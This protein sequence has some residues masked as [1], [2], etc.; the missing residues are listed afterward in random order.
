M[1]QKSWLSKDSFMSCHNFPFTSDI[2]QAMLLFLWRITPSALSQ[3]AEAINIL[4]QLL[5][6]YIHS[7][8]WLLFKTW[9]RTCL[10]PSQCSRCQCSASSLLASSNS[11]WLCHSLPVHPEC[12]LLACAWE[13][14]GYWMFFEFA[15]LIIWAFGVFFPPPV[16]FV[17][18][19]ALSPRNNTV[20]FF[21]PQSQH[22]ITCNVLPWL[23]YISN[24]IHVTFEN[25]S[26]IVWPG[27]TGLPSFSSTSEMSCLS[28]PSC[29]LKWFFL[30]CMWSCYS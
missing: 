13:P 20:P 24:R 21:S 5:F 10:P 26:H 2:P 18:W 23:V 22:I 8:S 9:W 19:S 17:A 15:V 29:L 28:D 12:C 4:W 16:Q 27:S 1:Y 30:T 3:V 14:E 7:Q 6:L 11:C 25:L